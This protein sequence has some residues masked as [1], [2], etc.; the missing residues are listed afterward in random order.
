MI[1][2]CYLPIFFFH[3]ENSIVIGHDNVDCDLSFKSILKTSGHLF[4]VNPNHEINAIFQNFKVNY[5]HSTFN[6][7]NLFYY[8]F[9]IFWA[10]ILNGL[11]ARIIGYIG[12]YYL[13]KNYFSIQ[14]NR[15]LLLL[16]LMYALMPFYTVYGISIMGLPFLYLIYVPITKREYLFRHWIY[17]VL[18][19]LCPFL[20]VGLFNSLLFCAHV[21]KRKTKM[22]TISLEFKSFRIWF[23]I[24][25]MPFFYMNSF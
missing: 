22:C 5:I 2:I 11:F 7:S 13:L 24:I 20:L 8:F 3:Q 4:C 6:F 9:S 18:Q 14:G 21:S 23:S 10:Y 25:Q 12:A 17:F 15:K 16:S 1:G 19:R